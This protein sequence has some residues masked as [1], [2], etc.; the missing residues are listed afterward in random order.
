MSFFNTNI[1][2]SLSELLQK[3][4]IG[5]KINSIENEYKNPY[6]QRKISNNKKLIKIIDYAINN[7]PY[8]KDVSKKIRFDINKF[9]KDINYLNDFPF[10]TKNII[11]EQ[12]TRLLDSNYDSRKFYIAKTGG[13][14]GPSCNIYYDDFAKDYSSA[15]TLYCRKKITNA[16]LPHHLHISSN[17]TSLSSYKDFYNFAKDEIKHFVLNRSDFKYKDLSDNSLNILYKYL[18][19][20]KFMLVHSHPSIMY[21]LANYI[22]KNRLP[23]KNNFRF[24][25]SSGEVLEDYMI[26]EIKK[27]FNCEIYNR[28]GLAEFGIVAYQGCNQNFDKLD[29]L[30]TE[31]FPES[32]DS[33]LIFTSLR[34]YMMPLIRYKTGD[35]GTIKEDP[36]KGFQISNLKGR[37]HDIFLVNDEVYFTG[38]IM[39][40]LDHKVG[41]V[42]EFQINLKQSPPHLNIVLEDNVNKDSH[43]IL[44]KEFFNDDF[45]I[46]FCEL[47]DLLRIG[48]QNK[49]RHLVS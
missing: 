22:K 32:F 47:D 38:Y 19:K 42:K 21:A 5:K 18:S 10:L 49:F 45:E 14:T 1:L 29:I 26:D 34:N 31:V 15:I 33:E 12:H 25:E 4:E 9:K 7:I 3:R 20:K 11:R 44:I 13:S 41:N 24:Y 8:Y 16:F 36:N 28:Y 37:T 2:F 17:L 40:I 48:D 30:D 6:K 46:F 35:L 27:T 23:L 43:K 39:D